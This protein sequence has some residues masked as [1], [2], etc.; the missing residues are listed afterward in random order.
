MKEQKRQVKLEVASKVPKGTREKE[1]PIKQ[2]PQLTFNKE[3][4]EEIM[5][6]LMNRIVAKPTFGDD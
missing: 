3:E 1:A 2:R 6:G 4:N 5:E